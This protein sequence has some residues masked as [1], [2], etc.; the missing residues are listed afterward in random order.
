MTLTN[1]CATERYVMSINTFDYVIINYLQ[2]CNIQ[3]HPATLHRDHL[4]RHVRRTKHTN[5]S[6]YRP[7][8]LTNACRAELSQLGVFPQQLLWAWHSHCQDN[9]NVQ[10]HNQMKTRVEISSIPQ[11]SQHKYQARMLWCQKMPW[12]APTQTQVS[13]WHVC[14]TWNTVG[15]MAAP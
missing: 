9:L 12:G 3:L 15:V 14:A 6:P 1:Q 5:L 8:V 2:H 4:C 7:S 13:T 10:E 11:P